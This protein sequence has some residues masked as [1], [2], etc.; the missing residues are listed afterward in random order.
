M[1]RLFSVLELIQLEEVIFVL[2]LHNVFLTCSQMLRQS[3]ERPKLLL[4]VQALTPWFMHK[5]E[6]SKLFLKLCVLM[7]LLILPLGYK[8][9]SVLLAN[10][11]LL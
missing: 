7:M 1:D 11:G 2:L 6:K 10:Y 8:I 3:S 5:Y 4:A 9:P